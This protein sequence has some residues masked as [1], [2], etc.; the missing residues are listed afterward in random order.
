MSEFPSRQLDKFVARLPAGMREQIGAEARRNGRTMNAEIV[1]RLESSL[2]ASP[3]AVLT[4]HENTAEA[5]IVW[6]LH[7]AMK[8][9]SQ[10]LSDL[11]GVMQGLMAQIGTLLSASGQGELRSDELDRSGPTPASSQGGAQP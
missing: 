5:D 7:D 11:K 6:E 1:S 4:I 10:E 3:R 8:G 9:V 2:S